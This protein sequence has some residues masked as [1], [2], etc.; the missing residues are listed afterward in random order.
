LAG[1]GIKGLELGAVSRRDRL[2]TDQEPMAP[3]G[4]LASW[5]GELV[6]QGSG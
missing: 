4:E 6:G 5:R 1:G 2:V 3:G